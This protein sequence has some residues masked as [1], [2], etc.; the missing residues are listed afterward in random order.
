MPLSEEDRAA[1]SAYLDGELDEHTTRLVEAR[2]TSD[3]DLRLE[4]ETLRQTWRLLDYLP[5]ATPSSGL[6]SKTLEKLEK[7]IINKQVGPGWLGWLFQRVP[8]GTVGW[9]GAVALALWVGYTLGGRPANA[10]APE[11]PLDGDEAL[12]RHLQILDR[13]PVYKHAQ[14]IDILRKLDQPDLFGDESGS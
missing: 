8:L 3:P 1:L 4:F 12:A 11:V 10:V 2:L 6:T 9:V 13:W 7:L 14:P 5:R